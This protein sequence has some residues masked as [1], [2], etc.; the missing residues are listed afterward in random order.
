MT[1]MRCMQVLSDNKI[2]NNNSSMSSSKS[3]NKL[4][5]PC[6]DSKLTF[7]LIDNSSGSSNSITRMIVNVD[8]SAACYDE[9]QHVLVSFFVLI[10]KYFTNFYDM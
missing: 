6:R 7:F 1:L 8:P 2:N 4:G 5:V 10:L 9:T 3:N